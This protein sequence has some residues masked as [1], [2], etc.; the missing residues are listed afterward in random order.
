MRIPLVQAVELSRQGPELCRAATVSSCT[1]PVPP[2]RSA[3]RE[4][5][6]DTARSTGRAVSAM[7]VSRC[8]GATPS[9]ETNAS[10]DRTGGA[11][12]CDVYAGS[13][14][15]SP[16]SIGVVRDTLYDMTAPLAPALDM[17]HAVLG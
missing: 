6:A 11:Q 3:I 14:V 9:A 5:S 7:A 2:S 17:R 15:V 8:G 1:E 10:S 16:S 4:P 13:P 12:S